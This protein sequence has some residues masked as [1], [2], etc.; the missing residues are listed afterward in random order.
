M[1]RSDLPTGGFLAHRSSVA[2]AV[3]PASSSRPALP[4]RIYDLADECILTCAQMEGPRV[5]ASP[6][7]KRETQA[8]TCPGSSKLSSGGESRSLEHRE[9]SGLSAFRILLFYIL[10]ILLIGLNGTLLALTSVNSVTYTASSS[11]Q[12]PWS[13]HTLCYNVS[14][15][16]GLPCCRISGGSRRRER[17]R[18]QLGPQRRESRT[19]RGNT[20]FAQSRPTVARVSFDPVHPVFRAHCT[21]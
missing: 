20:R 14:L 17:G 13:L 11:V 7:A 15:C 1:P 3:L 5:W 21:T 2:L 10:S 9:Q 19:V 6:Q 18:S 8:R 12:L 16:T 4:V